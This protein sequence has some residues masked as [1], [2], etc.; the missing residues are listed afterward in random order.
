MKRD[1]FS[2]IMKFCHL[3]DNEKYIPKGQPGY[4][5]LFKLRPFMEPLNANFQECYTLHREVSVDEAMVEFKGR[6][7][8]I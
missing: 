6:L 4:D 7:S 8:F 1:R 2:L 3:A 5:P